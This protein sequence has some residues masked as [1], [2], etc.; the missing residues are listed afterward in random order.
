MI[1]ENPPQARPRVSAH[2]FIK[3]KKLGLTVDDAIELVINSIGTKTGSTG[4]KLPG[5]KVKKVSEVKIDTSLLA[6]EATLSTISTETT[7]AAL[8]AKIDE[9]L[10]D[11][12][13]AKAQTLPVNLTLPYNFSVDHD[14]WERVTIPAGVTFPPYD[15]ASLGGTALDATSVLGGLGTGLICGL[16]SA[17]GNLLT[18]NGQGDMS[19][20]ITDPAGNDIDLILTQPAELLETINS[21]PVSSFNYNYNPGDNK[22]YR[23]PF[24]L[25]NN[26][27][28]VVVVRDAAG[29]EIQ[30]LDQ[31]AD[32][33][34][35]LTN[36]L[37]IA[38]YLRA[39]DG[40]NWDR[41]GISS[42][43]NRN[44]NVRLRHGALENHILGDGADNV[45]N[46]TN[47]LVTGSF[48]YGF[49]GATWDRLRID[50]DDNNIAGGS[51]HLVIIALN[52]YWNGTNWARN[53]TA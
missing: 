23:Q 2:L 1:V 33:E 29:D 37:V 10:D 47:Q 32:N 3:L 7:L 14:R 13:I 20:I 12:I 42:G 24:L 44:L 15:L 22:W 35:N 38:S 6:T 17:A 43:A 16:G 40:T 8:N 27:N 39:F 25:Q 9:E 52:Y 21:V 18:I 51:G 53:I 26:M 19:S 11:N 5:F 49:D 48:L 50:L 31:G 34:S 46:T 36:Q 28:L 41:V 30:V 4:F 45:V